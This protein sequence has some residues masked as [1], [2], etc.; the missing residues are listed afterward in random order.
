MR[1]SIIAVVLG[2][3][4]LGEPFGLRMALSAAVVLIGVAL[5]RS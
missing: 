2:A 1:I 4:V 5:V 3:L